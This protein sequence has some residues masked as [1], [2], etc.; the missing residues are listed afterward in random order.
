ME[1]GADPDRLEEQTPGD[2]SGSDPEDNRRRALTSTVGW[3][4]S[5]LFCSAYQSSLCSRVKSIFPSLIC[6]F[7]FLSECPT[8]CSPVCPVWY[9]V[10]GFFTDSFCRLCL[11]LWTSVFISLKLSFCCIQSDISC[12]QTACLSVTHCLTRIRRI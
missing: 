10:L 6:L 11:V 1:S 2:S 12:G 4:C 8:P 7:L 9:S 5:V 3:F